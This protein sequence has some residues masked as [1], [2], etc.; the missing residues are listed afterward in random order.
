MKAVVVFSG[1][2]DSTVLLNHYVSRLASP[3]ILMY[4]EVH[5]LSIFYGQRHHRELVAAVRI[6]PELAKRWKR[7][8]L[9]HKV[10]QLPELAGILTGSSQT[11]PSVSVPHGHY[12]EE[13]MKATVVPNRNMIL[14]SLAIGYAVSIKADV[15]AYGAHAGDHAIYPDCRPEFVAHM[16]N[17]TALCDWSPPKLLAPFIFNS[18]ADIAKRGKV[19]NAPMELSYSCYEGGLVHCGLCGTCQE[20]REAFIKAG[21]SDPTI[22]ASTAPLAEK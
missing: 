4:E 10:L 1:G 11:D 6:V 13:S 18:K 19:E 12:A 17:V 21:I 9:V 22:Y 3:N 16:Q 14:L 15:V 20:R 7:T 8:G 2:L 5:A